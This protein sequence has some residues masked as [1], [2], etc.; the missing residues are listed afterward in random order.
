[1]STPEIQRDQWR[2][3]ARATGS[4]LPGPSSG[5]I[6]GSFVALVDHLIAAQTQLISSYLRIG[7]S[8]ALPS[9]PATPTATIRHPRPED[10]QPASTP[11]PSDPAAAP[12]A[13][14]IAARAYQIFAER[15][16]EP[17]DPVDDWRRAEAE[18]RAE[19][20]G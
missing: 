4:S 17:G 7:L 6:L 10:D 15:G 2:D 3:A 18:L 14:A 9:R 1:M 13:D 12:A 11:A 16:L 8:V 5:A 19:T 20:T